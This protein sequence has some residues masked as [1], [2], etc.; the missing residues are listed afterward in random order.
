MIYA[1]GQEDS[2][3]KEEQ[4]VQRIKKQILDLG[5]ML[6]GSLS[7]QWNVCGTL[8]CKCK[9]PQKPIRHGPYYQLSFSVKGRS[10]TLFIRPEEASEVRKRIQRYQRFKELA[11]ALTQAYVDLARKQK[12]SGRLEA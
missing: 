2:V 4:T 6:P 10:S 11:M 1:I 5:P 9:D 12:I 3:M 7:E 8:G